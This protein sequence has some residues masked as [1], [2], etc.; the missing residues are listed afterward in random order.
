MEAELRQGDE[1][2]TADG[3]KLGR[4]DQLL[5]RLEGIDPELK[6]YASYLIVENFDLGDEYYVPTDFISGRDGDSGRLKLSVKHKRV[7]SETWTRMPDF[8]ARNRYRKEN[9]PGR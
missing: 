7:L 2:W 5:H 9:L 8:V 4:A 3:H 1:I 6:L